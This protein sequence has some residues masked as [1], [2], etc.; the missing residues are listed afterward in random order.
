ME[1]SQKMQADIKT[2]YN[3][4]SMNPLTIK[5]YIQ[6]LKDTA[7]VTQ[8]FENAQ[9]VIADNS[10]LLTLSEHFSIKIN[11][12]IRVL[13]GQVNGQLMGLSR[14]LSEI[15]KNANDTAEKFKKEIEKLIPTFRD[16]IKSHG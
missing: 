11:E 16:K 1:R 5:E 14:R 10:D 8:F 9:P 12:N 6:F 7:K 4:I 15:Q 2:N 13:I 3:L